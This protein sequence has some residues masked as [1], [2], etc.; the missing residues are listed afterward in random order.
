ME[1]SLAPQAS[2]RRGGRIVLE[3]TDPAIPLDRVPYFVTDLVRLG[4]VA[5]LM[6]VLLFAGAVFVIPHVIH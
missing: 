3:N 1:M 4:I 6:V 2:T 5:G